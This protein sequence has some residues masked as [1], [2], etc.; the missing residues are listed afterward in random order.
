MGNVC[1][2]ISALRYLGATVELVSDPEVLA[3]ADCIV[4]LG[5]GSLKKGKENLKKKEIIE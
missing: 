2:V 5:V 3:K 4:L 1:S